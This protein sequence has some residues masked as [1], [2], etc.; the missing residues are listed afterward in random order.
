MNIEEFRE[1]CLAKPATSES[2]PFDNKTLVFKVHNKM[3]SL[4]GIENFESVNLKCEPEYA[5]ELREKFEGVQPGYHMNKQHWNT[6]LTDG[7][8]PDDLLYELIDHSYDLV[9][10]GLRKKVRDSLK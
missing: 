1:Y 4:A 9:A 6:V 2:L 7:S 5:I 8:V 10:R 3:F